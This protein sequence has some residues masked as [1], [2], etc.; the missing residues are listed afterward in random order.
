[1]NEGDIPK[2]SL[3]TREGHYMFLVRDCGVFNEPYSFQR[4]MKQ[5]FGP[6]LVFFDEIWAYNKTLAAHVAQVL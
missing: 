3:C 6:F 4:L 2:T 1:M 5:I